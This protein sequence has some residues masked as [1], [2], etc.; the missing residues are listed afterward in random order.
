MGYPMTWKRF[1]NR[2]SLQEGGYANAQLTGANLDSM[3]GWPGDAMRQASQR[4]RMIM[5][6]LRRLEQDVVDE[7]AIC[8]QIVSRTGIDKDT[9]AAVLK[10]FMEI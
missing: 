5:G 2:N 9:V 3:T 6:D 8:N 10:A 4:F 7:K 1:I